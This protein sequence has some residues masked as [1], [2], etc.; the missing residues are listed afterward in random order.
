MSARNS[1]RRFAA[2]GLLVAIIIASVL[3]A[4]TSY[5][6]RSG[7]SAVLESDTAAEAVIEYDTDTLEHME[8]ATTILMPVDGVH[9]NTVQS[10]WHAPRGGGR[11]HL[12]QDIF[13]DRGTPIYSATIG[14]IAKM[15]F[16]SKGGNYV[17]IVG[18][19]GWE[20]YYAHLNTI[21]RDIHVGDFVTIDTQIGA[22]GNTGNATASHPH[23]HFSVYNADGIA[24]DPLQFLSDRS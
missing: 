2:E 11:L 16:E 13:A 10:S 17:R 8:H 21:A 1:L 22:V 14:R 9:I 23:L 4:S 5:A 20:Y 15:G 3:Y 19:G 6:T 12:G 24:I 7:E 18:P